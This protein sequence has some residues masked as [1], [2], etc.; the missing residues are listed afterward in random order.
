MRACWIWDWSEPTR[1]YGSR[2]LFT[3]AAIDS[4]EVKS[5]SSEDDMNKTEYEILSKWEYST[6]SWWSAELS[7]VNLT[8]FNSNFV[9]V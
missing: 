9:V 6:K 4:G 5:Q 3:E 2:W 7:N 1:P 8:Y